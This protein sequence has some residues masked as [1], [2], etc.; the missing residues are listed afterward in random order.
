MEGFN[1]EIRNVQGFNSSPKTYVLDVALLPET[2]LEQ[3]MEQAHFLQ[4]NLTAEVIDKALE[5]LPAEVR[6]HTV[7]EIKRTLLSRLAKIDET[8]LTYFGVLNKYAIVTG[9]DKDDWFEI[10]ILN[11][12]EIEVKGYRNIK[13]KKKKQFF[14][15]TFK[16]EITKEIWVYGLDDDDRFEVHGESSGNIKVRLI[17]GHNNDIYDLKQ[18]GNIAI[19][20]FKSKK[21]TYIDTKNAKV[22]LTDDYDVNTYLPLQVR[23]SVNQLIPTIGFNP[24]D[25]L[26][27]G[28]SDTYTYNGFRQ[29]PFSQ[30]HKVDASFYFATSG[31]ELGYSG[32][33]AEVFDN[34]NFEFAARFTSPNYSVNFF[35]FG[36]ETINEDDD[37]GMDY[38]RVK[39][40]TVKA[41]PAWCGEANWAESSE[42]GF[43]MSLLM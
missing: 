29:N 3:W 37:L 42:Q 19:Y 14:G 8:A 24:D 2:T 21:N 40:Q 32:E 23:N 38:N 15:K 13:G 30:R 41:A 7:D 12:K 35:G 31:F 4:K 1:E 39:L 25:G 9:T 43:L 20:D 33:F 22:K 26:K 36:N 11:K 16:S 6:D 27:I 34:W 17:G 28:L 10:N 5:S 18:G